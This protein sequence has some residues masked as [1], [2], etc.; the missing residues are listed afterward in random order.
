M[1]CVNNCGKEVESDGKSGFVHIDSREGKK[2][3]GSYMCFPLK[4]GDNDKEPR[5]QLSASSR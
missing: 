1:N 3:P 2:I 5:F 4:R